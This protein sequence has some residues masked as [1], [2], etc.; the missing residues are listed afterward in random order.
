MANNARCAIKCRLDLVSCTVLLVK[1]PIR[2]VR[3]LTV[4][5]GGR[6]SVANHRRLPG[7]CSKKEMKSGRRIAQL[8]MLVARLLAPYASDIVRLCPVL[9]KCLS[10]VICHNSIMCFKE[11]LPERDYATFGSLL[12]QIRLSS[13]T[14]VRPTQGVETFG[15]I[16]RHFVPLPSSDIRAKFYGDRPREPFHRG[17]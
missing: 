15:N 12:S 3:A 8:L 2:V 16:F 14:F 1:D 7:R 9:M 4:S 10:N 11:F 6:L 13:V 5:L 17:R